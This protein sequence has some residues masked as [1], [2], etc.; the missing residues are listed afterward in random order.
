MQLWS[1]YAQCEDSSIELPPLICTTESCDVPRQLT[2][3]SHHLLLLS[4]YFHHWEA[5]ADSKIW[6][7]PLEGNWGSSDFSSRESAS[8]S[9]WK[10]ISWLTGHW[11]WEGGLEIQKISPKN[12]WSGIRTYFLN[13][14]AFQGI[15]FGGIFRGFFL[16]WR[17]HIRLLL[18]LERWPCWLFCISGMRT[19]TAIVCMKGKLLLLLLVV[20]VGLHIVLKWVHIFKFIY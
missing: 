17:P 18:L 3:W 4:S 1:Y 7:P 13:G 8:Y 16:G 9:Y 6:T 10:V 11:G 15:I 14:W 19:A 20:M 2:Y 5:T 12:V